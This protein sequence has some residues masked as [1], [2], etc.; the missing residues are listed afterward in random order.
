MGQKG[1]RKHTSSVPSSKAHIQPAHEA[2]FA[3]HDEELLVVGPEEHHAV[4]GAVE[5]LDGIARRLGKVP[6][7]EVGEGLAEFSRQVV[8]GRRMVRVSKDANVGVQGLQGCSR[9]LDGGSVF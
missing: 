6:V 9:M 3:I 1:G 5:S 2:E 8:P 4:G 7:G